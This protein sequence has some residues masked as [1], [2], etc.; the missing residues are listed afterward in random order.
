MYVSAEL[1]ANGRHLAV[2]RRSIILML[3]VKKQFTIVP[4]GKSPCNFLRLGGDLV[5]TSCARRKSS[6]SGN[7]RLFLKPVKYNALCG[8]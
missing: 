3:C 6:K 8:T 1:A 2:K 7:F 5:D 4:R